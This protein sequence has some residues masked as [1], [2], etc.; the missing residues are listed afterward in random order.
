MISGLLKITVQW[1]CSLPFKDILV[2][3]HKKMIKSIN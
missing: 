3:N 1:N 2:N